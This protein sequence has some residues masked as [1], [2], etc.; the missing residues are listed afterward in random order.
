MFTA[1]WGR[2]SRGQW[3][4]SRRLGAAVMG[5]LGNGLGYDNVVWGTDALWTGAPQWQIAG[6]R[7]IEIPEAKQK[8]YG[9]KPLGPAPDSPIKNAI[10]GGTNAKLYNYSP[11][12]RSA[13]ENDRF[14]QIKGTYEKYGEGRSNLRYGYVAKPVA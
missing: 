4:P 8:K 2:S 10:F 12:Q 6:L 14:A 5:I 13:L 9:F 1:T 11:Q 3:S 7:R